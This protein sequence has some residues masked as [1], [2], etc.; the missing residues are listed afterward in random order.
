M[1]HAWLYTVRSLAEAAEVVRRL[2]IIPRAGHLAVGVLC[3]GHGDAWYVHVRADHVSGDVV[4]SIDSALNA[5][6]QPASLNLHDLLRTP[7][8]LALAGPTS[9][10]LKGLCT[11]EANQATH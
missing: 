1:E 8:H 5:L 2:D 10:I 6:G 4:G 3:A 7:V 9:L 11:L